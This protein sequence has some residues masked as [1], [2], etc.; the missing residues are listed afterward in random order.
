[1]TIV[2]L[3][4]RASP[5]MYFHRFFL[6]NLSATCCSILFLNSNLDYSLIIIIIKGLNA[7]TGT[8]PSEIEFLKDLKELHL[9]G[10][11][12]TGTI[13]VQLK[14]LFLNKT[15]TFDD[16][17]ASGHFPS[18]VEVMRDSNGEIP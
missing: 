7:F 4:R 8:I 17:L 14:T 5:Y 16:A 12:F 10:N 2:V 6:L 9:E 3:I 11:Q 13:P 15:L 1:V 18:E